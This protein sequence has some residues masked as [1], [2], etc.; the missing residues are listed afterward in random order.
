MRSTRS[1]SNDADNRIKQVFDLTRCSLGIRSN[2][3]YLYLQKLESY[4]VSGKRDINRHK[5]VRI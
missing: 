3:F 5:G 1:L 4:T 2:T